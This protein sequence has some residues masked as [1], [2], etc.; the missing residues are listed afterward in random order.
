[1]MELDQQNQ[2]TETYMDLAMSDMDL[3]SNLF[4][5]STSFID[6]MREFS[7]VIELRLL[8]KYH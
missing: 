1:M 2:S 8:F 4:A 6:K 5:C 7:F 3:F